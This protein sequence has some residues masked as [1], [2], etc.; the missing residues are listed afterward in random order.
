MP[1]FEPMTSQSL[2]LELDFDLFT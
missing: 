1:G 2:R